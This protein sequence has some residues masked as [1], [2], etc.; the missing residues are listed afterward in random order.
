MQRLIPTLL[1]CAVATS[2]SASEGACHP[3]S[4]RE[5]Q[6]TGSATVSLPPDQVSFSLGVESRSR[7]VAEAFRGNSAK[8][9]AIIATLK[10]MGVK[11]EELRTSDLSINSYSERNDQVISYIVTNRITVTRRDLTNIGELIQAAVE[12]GANQAD[13]LYFSTTDT[14]EARKQ[15]LQMAYADAHDK[16]QQLATLAGTG[17]GEAICISEEGGARPAPLA[18]A[19][20]AEMAADAP[21]IEAGTQQVSFTVGI[22]FELK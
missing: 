9:N 16:A 14:R 11:K 5:I 18:Y 7:K 3:A 10:K 12:Q 21:V 1:L 17:L 13:A 19:M 20:K 8:A 6:V 2:A 15:A 4:G 22:V